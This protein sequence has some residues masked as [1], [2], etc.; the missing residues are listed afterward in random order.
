MS[1]S[2]QTNVNSLVAQQNL[3]ITNKFQS[4]TIAQLT[5]G[6]RINSAGDDAAGLAVANKF[7]SGVAELTQGVANGNDAVAQL[8]IMDGGMSNI[9]MILDRLK[10]LATQSASGTFTGDRGTLNNEF[11]T[12]I[13]EIDRQAQSI[14]LDTGGTFA[15]SLS[16]Y[17]GQ[18]S[19]SGNGSGGSQALSNANVG[20]DLSQS[21][22]DAGSLGLKG[23]KAIAGTVASSGTDIGS[24]SSNGT[25]VA[26]IVNSAAGNAEAKA[27]Y[28]SFSFSGPGF[29]DNSKV[30]VQA[31]LNGVS[32]TS[33]LVAAI[34][35]GIAN[36]A[37]GSTQAAQALK[38]AGIVA[39]VN[40]DQYGHQQLAFSS[41]NTAFQVQA[42]D[43]MAN[44]LMGN[45]AGPGSP[46]GTAVTSTVTG[47]TAALPTA[48]FNPTDVSVQVS[49]AGLAGPVNISLSSSDGTV[50]DATADIIKQVNQNSQLQAAGIS[51]SLTADNK[52]QFASATGASFNVES[53]G[54]TTNALGLGSFV[55]TAALN[56][57]AAYSDITAATSYSSAATG[58][59][60]ATLGFSLDGGATGGITPASVT[61]SVTGSGY[62][63]GGTPNGTVSN[64][65]GALGTLTLALNGS[66]TP[67]TVDFTKDSNQG[68]AETLQQAANFI[69]S[70]IQAQAG[71]GSDVQLATVNSA[72]N[73]LK[74]SGPADGAGT[75]VASGAA[76]S[77][78]GLSAASGANIVAAS[79]SAGNT[80]SVNLAG[81]DATSALAAGSAAAP[82]NI[83]TGTNTLALKIDGVAVNA[84]FA[85]DAN[86]AGSAAIVTSATLGASPSS[87]LNISALQ[88]GV[89]SISTGSLGSSGAASTVDVHTGFTAAAPTVTG[90]SIAANDT[91]ATIDLTSFAAKA[92]SVT[93][94][95]LGVI[96]DPTLNSLNLSQYA[97]TAAIATGGSLGTDANSAVNLSAF[98]ATAATTTSTKTLAA[99]GLDFSAFGATSAVMNGT[100]VAPD[101]TSSIAAVTSLATGTPDGK[102][103]IN[104]SILDLSGCTSLD[105]VVTQI[106][107]DVAGVTASDANGVLTL[108]TT[109]TGASATIDVAANSASKALGLAG[110]S[111]I[112]DST[113]AGV[114]ATKLSV[115]VDSTTKTFD[116]SGVTTLAGIVSAINAG[117]TGFGATVASS[118]GGV[119]SLTS[120]TTGSTSAVNVTNNGLS[121]ALGLTS[122]VADNDNAGTNAKDL[123]VNIDGKG[124]LNIDISGATTVGQVASKINAAL[125][126]AG[127]Y[128]AGYDSVASGST[129]SLTLTSVGT[130]S[131]ASVQIVDSAVSEAVGLT[132][133]ADSNNTGVDA[134][135]L[136]LK[137]DGLGEVDVDVSG[138][139]DMTSL[140]SA[141]NTQTQ[142]T[143]A[144]GG[145][146]GAYTA[147]AAAGTGAATGSLVL[148]GRTTGSATGNI[149]ILDNVIS[150]KLG[151]TSGSNVS[152]AGSDATK[153]TV[154]IDGNKA[155]SIDLSG[156]GATAT[157]TQ[158]KSAINTALDAD[159]ADGY[160]AATNYAT[161]KAG[162]T[163]TLVLT[164][165]NV[166]SSLTVT[167]NAISKALG[168]ATGTADTT[169]SRANQTLNLQIDGHQQV[170]VALDSLGTTASL[171][172]IANA[173]NT[174]L[175]AATA[176]GYGAAYGNVATANAN[177]TI[178]LSGV[179]GN[180]TVTVVNSLMSNSLG[181]TTSKSNATA[182]GSPAQTLD[183][184]IDG[185]ATEQVSL[186]GIAGGATPKL[187]DIAAAINTAFANDTANYGA[188]YASA[189]TA[190]ADGTISI[191][192]VNKGSATGS[193]TITNNTVAQAL[194]LTS[195]TAASVTASGKDETVAQVVSF[196]NS[197][198]QK[199]LGTSTAANIVS[200]NASGDIQIASQTKGANSS[201]SVV[202]AGTTGGL[203]SSLGL[204]AYVNSAASGQA[205]SLQSVVDGLKVAFNS[206]T[207]LQAAGLTAQINSG[208]NALE[209]S[210]SNGTQ[211]RLDAWGTQK[212][213]DNSDLGFGDAG[214][215]F[216]NANA[217]TP[218]ST[219]SVVDTQ[220]ASA[221]GTSAN[222]SN[223]TASIS[224]QNMQFGNDNQSISI[225]ANSSA[226]VAQTPLTITLQN[227]SQAQTGANIDS[228]ISAINTKLQQSENSTLR[229]IT[230]VSETAADGSES[231]N[232]IS[233][234]S[235]FNVSVSSSAGAAVGDGLNGGKAQTF[236]S[237]MNGSASSIAIDTQQGA[238]QALLAISS[239]VAKLGTAQAAI[240][241][242]EN[243]LGYAID[244]ANSQITNFSSAESQIRDANVAQQA[245]NLSKAQVLSQAA[246]AAMAQANSAPQGVLALLR[247]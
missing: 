103:I 202:G 73:T 146:G 112:A 38:N 195:G 148:S 208:T 117:G 105:S 168:L 218:K 94:T 246:I 72:T 22:V 181:L 147:V 124:A 169:N 113:Q 95:A 180:G 57:A 136:K 30:S 137:A 119:L 65:A 70:Q 171:T 32:D 229:S 85:N 1:V 69:N 243:Q 31:N 233:S 157:A 133:G 108:T 27:G 209:I 219:A 232:F 97:A 26:D 23:M 46:T 237:A 241:I 220:G 125:N 216:T 223:N 116:L 191:S 59:G 110:A 173:I 42:G 9:S 141:I 139:T 77:A 151:L 240:G 17:L 3:S 78:L 204:G 164:G 53:V 48:V 156:L 199:V 106:G 152:Q 67:V 206:N 98:A 111:Q 154:Q 224:F 239:A 153:L 193:L 230:A 231:I 145:F 131:T 37:G 90:T 138:V 123:T 84:N 44:A 194:G 58:N 150:Q 28:A 144:N 222:G 51:A 207:T 212:G 149:T 176:S 134:T 66:T 24:G 203:A 225:S 192:S 14:G 107:S 19:G 104:G 16:V 215:A 43:Q 122:G 89:A 226:G 228:A 88:G 189:A 11:Q 177:G 29:S 238:Q 60:V 49:G 187:S 210:S 132:S 217:V 35:Q 25:T 127:G 160:T 162:N 63:G 214:Q 205:R 10:T 115:T 18:G 71:Y 2:I 244:L 182:T 100:A 40:T 179:Q 96:A 101:D 102:L 227:N 184:S 56:G 188:A 45:F 83:A 165:L 64:A 99:T 186:T 167:N 50:G 80:V 197:T 91:A 234:L 196:L 120:G 174:A 190:N 128:G 170:D 33:S 62:N 130:G 142:K 87:T 12:D 172:S 75:I 61:G 15:K 68:A 7:R 93:G 39:T 161:L 198:A 166:G 213:T 34:N 200:Q 129:G 81:G 135:K 235:S 236:S 183:V 21:T 4:Q 109:A 140:V 178:T 86:A 47:R 121:S 155:E 221:I 118:T 247:G 114:D 163:G 245:A 76:A 74:L 92:A 126:A 55:T 8:Q 79:G 52:L 242:G 41:S 175:K 185:K 36:A 20:L 13:G 6:Y 82:T 158:V 54:D 211:F 5:S 143:V 201:V 159:T